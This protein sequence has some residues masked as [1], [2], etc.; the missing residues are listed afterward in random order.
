VIE[1]SLRPDQSVEAQRIIDGSLA[2]LDGFMTEKQC[3][4]VVESLRLPNGALI[5]VPVF[6]DVAEDI[7]NACRSTD[8]VRLMEGNEE[9]ALLDVSSVFRLDKVSIAEH[10][11]AT[12]DPR[13]AGVARLD[14]LGEWAIGGRLRPPVGGASEDPQGPVAVRRQFELRGW[15]TRA[16]FQT[17]NIPHRAHELLHWQ[18][19]D[20][21]D[22]L[23]IH[24][25][26][27]ARKAGDFT[28]EAV[29]AAYRTLVARHLPTERVL[30]SPIRLTMRYAGPREAVFHAIIRRNFGCTHF[31]VGRDHAGVGSFYAPYDAHALLRSVEADLGIDILYMRGPAYCSVCARIVTDVTCDHFATQPDAIE[32]VSGT[33][34]RT[35]IIDGR[36]VP[37]R[38]VRADVLASLD[39]IQSFLSETDAY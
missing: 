28:P 18:A 35:S 4:S 39:G 13:H 19:L 8:T 2:P 7:A 33:W 5:G 30:L 37:D 1:V 34:L 26:I 10:V 24:P 23:L 27:G 32:E 20:A 6:L 12:H 25:L 38:L 17:R 22:G 16:G 29:M 11:F 36:A 31:V 21:C 9:I 15:R 3:A 14:R